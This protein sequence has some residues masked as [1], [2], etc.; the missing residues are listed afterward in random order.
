MV[1]YSK[2]PK[3]SP[4]RS[5]LFNYIL[6]EGRRQYSA[7]RVLYRVHGTDEILTLGELEEKSRRFASVLHHK[8]GLKPNDV[9]AFLANN[10]VRGDLL[11]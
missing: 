3:P 8:F 1:F 7:D 10:S 5:D 9:V 2:L 4:P 11:L 6:K